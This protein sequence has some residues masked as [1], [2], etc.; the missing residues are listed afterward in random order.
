MRGANLRSERLA[1]LRRS[2]ERH[3]TLSSEALEARAA[4][5][6]QWLKPA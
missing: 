4:L 2:G 6:E 5:I 3:S 1:Q